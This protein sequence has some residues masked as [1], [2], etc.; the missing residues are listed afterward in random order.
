MESEQ[1]PINEGFWL[2]YYIFFSY[3]LYLTINFLYECMCVFVCG[4]KAN[5]IENYLTKHKKA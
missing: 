5:Q 3:R 4:F 2:L 1:N